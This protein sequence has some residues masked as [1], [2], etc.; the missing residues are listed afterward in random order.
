MGEM[1][2]IRDRA[3]LESAPAASRRKHRIGQWRDWSRWSNINLLRILG[4]LALALV[5][6][7][8]LLEPLT[9]LGFA[10]RITHSVGQGGTMTL[11]FIVAATIG[12]NT[13]SRAM[14]KAAFGPEKT[15][16]QLARDIVAQQDDAAAGLVALGDKQILFSDCGQA[17]L[18]Y[19]RRGRTWVVLADPVGPRA[20]W[21]NLVTKMVRKAKAA[22]HRVAFYQVSQAFLP[23]AVDSGF[24]LFK[25]GDQAVVDLPGFDLKGGDWLK[26]RRSINRAERDGLEFAVLAPAEVA[27]VMDELGAVSDTW[28]AH[29]NATEKGFSLGTFQRGYVAS[30]PLAVIR[31]AGRIVAFANILT[32]QTR[33]GAFIDLMRHVPGVHRGAMDLLFVRT[34][35][36]L[37]AEGY[38]QLNLGMAPLSGL[39]NR[40]CAPL[41]HRLGRFVFEH[42]E[43]FYNFKGVQAFKTKF[44]PEWQPRYLAVYDKRQV[45]ETVIDI[46]LLIGGGLRGLVRR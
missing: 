5:G 1:S 16:I 3:E 43:R 4:C 45:P 26:L 32:T 7:E 24:R 44:H 15:D 40:S 12:R 8:L 34:I 23:T 21:P 27:L 38:Q 11:F 39:S 18:M 41:W 10:Y 35:Q 31:L 17:F 20:V 30:H 14:P 19:G 33:S 6:L 37:Q 9:E 22:G 42:G 46:V 36:H 25:L 13:L 29:H 28:L 2:Q